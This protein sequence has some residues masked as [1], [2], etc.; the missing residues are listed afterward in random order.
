M[1]IKARRKAG[2]RT[3]SRYKYIQ[4][5]R[6]VFFFLYMYFFSL[7][8]RFLPFG[9]ASSVFLFIIVIIFVKAQTRCELS[10]FHRAGK[11]RGRVERASTRSAKFDSCTSSQYTHSHT[12]S[13]VSS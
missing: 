12:G 7:S 8:V 4:L 2:S 9:V 5:I 11:E 10:T 3:S 13:V 6:F 1:L